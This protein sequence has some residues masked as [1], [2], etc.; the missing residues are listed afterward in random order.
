MALDIRQRNERINQRFTELWAS[1]TY[2]HKTHVHRILAAEF[3]LS[4]GR[5]RLLV[6]KGKPAAPSDDLDLLV[7]ALKRANDAQKREIED[8]KAH[9]QLLN[10]SAEPPPRMRGDSDQISAVLEDL[11]GLPRYARV[12]VVSDEHMP[13]HD[14]RAITM[15][16]LI[17][18]Y[19]NPDLT[20]FDGDEFDFSALSLHYV[21]DRAD[22]HTD[23][24]R[25]VR[26]HWQGY[27]DRMGGRYKIF[28]DGN[29]NARLDTF[30][31][32]QAQQFGDTLEDDYAALVRYN[33]KVL[34]RGGLEEIDIGG[35]HVHHGE[36][37]GENS[38]K[39]ALVKD[40]GG[41]QCV[42]QGHTHG[43]SIYVH[44][45]K[46]P[47]QERFRVVTSVTA[48]FGGNKPPRYRARKTNLSKWIPASTVYQV[49]M[50]SDDVHFTL[51][52]YHETPQGGLVAFYGS[53]MFRVNAAGEDEAPQKIVPFGAIEAEEEVA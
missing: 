17:S 31:N 50:H 19:V 4:E 15:N 11:R 30:L 23:A 24:F 33:G 1:G 36:R 39:N 46:I 10:N 27:V 25:A 12:H 28:L 51:I 13:D 47:G 26:P 40:F 42:H 34:W 7:V 44:S 21:V 18:R 35:L 43:I 14:P 9:I 20:L 41:A 45:V 37:T 6:G 8:L 3:G 5:I 38:A 22:G 53:K 48:G 49:D 2:K 29:H 52:P 32:M 16:C